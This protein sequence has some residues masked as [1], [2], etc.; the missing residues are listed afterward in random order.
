MKKSIGGADQEVF[1][2]WVIE[3]IVSHPS[4]FVIVIISP[5]QLR[6]TDIGVAKLFNNLLTKRCKVEFRAA[7]LDQEN[8][9]KNPSETAFGRLSEIS[10]LYIMGNKTAHKNLQGFTVF[11]N[12]QAIIDTV[13]NDPQ[14]HPI[15]RWRF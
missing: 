15:P 10:M 11:L 9:G 2:G 4:I 7:F 3:A 14:T 8:K 5:T 6:N 1:A 13:K 12:Q